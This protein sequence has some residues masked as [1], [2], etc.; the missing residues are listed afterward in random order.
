MT[1]LG[2]AVAGGIVLLA[3]M[4]PLFASWDRVQTQ[5][6]GARLDPPDR[7]HLMGRDQ[8]GRDLMARIIYGAG[9]HAVGLSVKH[10]IYYGCAV[11]AF[12]GYQ[13]AGRTASFRIRVQRLYGVF[14]GYC[15]RL[16]W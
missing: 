4:S 15:W 6:L 1:K 10:I 8:L 11:G 14:R 7:V 13:A 9:F 16:Q 5:N 2:L 3:V 12:A